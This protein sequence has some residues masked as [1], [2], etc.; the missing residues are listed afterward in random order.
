MDRAIRHGVPALLA[1]VVALVV[2]MAGCSPDDTGSQARRVPAGA[3]ARS[4]V[5]PNAAEVPAADAACEPGRDRQVQQLP[6]VTAPAVVVPPTVDPET[7][8]VLAPGFTVP[9]LVVDTG[10]IVRHAAPGGCLGAV[11]ISG[12][13]I[14]EVTIPGTEVDGKSYPPVTVPAVSRPAVHTHEVCQVTRDGEALGVTR[15][16]VVREGFSRNGAARPGDDLVPTVRIDPVRVPDVDVEPTRLERRELPGRDDVGLFADGE[17]T[18]FVAPAA[19]LFDTDRYALRAD[20]VDAL[21]AIASKIRRAG[22]T[23]ILVEGH[24][25]DRGDADYG[26]VLSERR[27]AAVATWL[28]TAGGLDRRII[29]TRGYGETRPAFPNNSDANRQ[30]NRR[31]VITA[32]W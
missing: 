31:V 9:P 20:A 23:R 6:D 1:L 24:T 12:V 32:F 30:R 18:S 13:T 16:G 2:T 21:R 27:A 19:V 7:G 8:E 5:L 17:R 25:D 3:D 22:P 10:C 29:S 11:D 28:A 14:P 26:Q 15:A 4:S